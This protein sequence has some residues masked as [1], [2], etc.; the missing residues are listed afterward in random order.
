MLYASWSRA[1][2]GAFIIG[3][4]ALLWIHPINRLNRFAVIGCLL[5][6]AIFVAAPDGTL[7]YFESWVYK[8][9][10]TEE[11]LAARAD[12]WQ[13][14]YQS[15]REKPLLGVGF[16]VTAVAEE[17]WDLES[18]RYLKVEQGSSLSALLGQVGLLGSVP[19]YLGIIWLLLRS[20][21]YARRVR[22]PWLSG[23]VAVGFVGFVN[24]FF[25]GWLAAPASGLYWLVV[26]QFFFLDAVM[27]NL[28][29]A[30]RPSAFPR[31]PNPRAALRHQATARYSHSAHHRTAVATRHVSG[32]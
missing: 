31:V 15:F 21:Q 9:R 26:F 32:H 10:V 20:L 6:F 29:P 8:G 13:R 1:S 27:S 22:D 19:I 7:R 17:H 25:E 18:F 30:G 28:K 24:S 11:L 16:G 5:L 3:M 23:V 14:G 4:A 12:E 2:V